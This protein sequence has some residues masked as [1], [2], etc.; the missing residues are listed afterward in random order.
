MFKDLTLKI[1]IK[2]FIVII[3]LKKDF[4]YKNIKWLW[5]SLYFIS[6]LDMN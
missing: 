6:N 1:S 5:S 3:L 4:F 2:N